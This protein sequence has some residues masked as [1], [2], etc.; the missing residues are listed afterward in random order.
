MFT[1]FSSLHRKVLINPVKKGDVKALH[2]LHKKCFWQ[3]WDKETFR[4]FLHDSQ[5]VGFLSLSTGETH[6]PTGFVLARTVADEAE[7]LSIAVDIDYRGYGISYVLMNVL[8]DYL[9][10]KQIKMLFLEVDEF[11]KRAR[12]L[13]KHF[14]CKVIGRRRG[15]YK[16]QSGHSDA[17]ILSRKLL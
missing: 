3:A 4:F 17:L 10:Q 13:Y 9:Y 14:D 16:S 7:I 1:T 6:C 5:V 11:N 15:Y 12:T 8:L 2:T